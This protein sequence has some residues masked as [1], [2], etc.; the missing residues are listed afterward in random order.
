LVAGTLSGLAGL[1]M[2]ELHC[3]NFEVPHL[4][5]WHTA[6]VL[7]SGGVGALLASGI[8]ARR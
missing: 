3:P 8:R 6:V 5:V 1:I 2:L 4:V 7:F